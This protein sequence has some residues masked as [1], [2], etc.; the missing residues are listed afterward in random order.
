MDPTTI[1]IIGFLVMFILMT[2]KLPIGFCFITVGFSGIICLS[3]WHTAINTLARMPFT[4]MTQYVFTCVPLFILM[5]LVV[6]NTGIA[7]DLFD[8]GHKWVGRIKG[9][10]AMATTLGVGA[11]SA[12]SGSSTA[13]A[14]TMSAICYPEMKRKNYSDALST[15]CIA[16]GGGID[17]MIPPSLGFVLYGIITEAS[18]GK[19]LIAGIIPGIIQVGS[20]LVAIYLLVKFKPRACPHHGRC[21]LYLDAKN[22][23]LEE[24]VVHSHP[25]HPGHGGNLLGMGYG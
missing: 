22:R 1:G 7:E 10:L 25:F 15:G 21:P 12:V 11:F 5:G 4:W 20:F 8:M 17:L 9:G 16:A 13:C 3:G 14:A 19:L 24:V 18:I 23:L 2:T 6:A